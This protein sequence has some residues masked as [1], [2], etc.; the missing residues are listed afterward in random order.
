M[1]FRQDAAPPLP[2]AKEWAAAHTKPRCEKVVARYLGDRGVP[3]FLPVVQNRRTYGARVRVSELPLF[4]GYV[5]FD[6]AA[7]EQREVYESGRVVGILVPPNP[8]HLHDDL[9]NLAVALMARRHT[10][11][12]SA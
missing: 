11:R 12:P 8:G 3:V 10:P 5:F 2:R 7:V 9:R 6:H 1:I 4:P